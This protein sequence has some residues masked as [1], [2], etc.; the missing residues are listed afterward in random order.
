VGEMSRGSSVGIPEHV[1][2]LP[3]IA[4][5]PQQRSINCACTPDTA[6]TTTHHRVH[7]TRLFIHGPPNPAVSRHQLV[8]GMLSALPCTGMT[9]V[10]RN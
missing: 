2:S 7:E 4:S 3:P 1:C 6:P 8:P 9:N 10:Y 5:T